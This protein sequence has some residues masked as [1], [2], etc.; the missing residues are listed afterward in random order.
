MSFTRSE[1]RNVLFYVGSNGQLLGGFFQAGSITEA[2]FFTI[3]ST[4]LLAVE[5]P[6]T[7][8]DQGSGQVLGLSND[9]LN[10]GNY[11]IF[12]QGKAS[13]IR[14]SSHFAYKV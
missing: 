5:K 11:N 9:V 13:I 8:Q 7:V 12:C 2:N 14:Y 10:P 1:W 6:L 3:L 4:V